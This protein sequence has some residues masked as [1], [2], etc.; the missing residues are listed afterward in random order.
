MALFSS[1]YT[2]YGPGDPQYDAHVV[3]PGA[4]AAAANAAGQPGTENLN[5]TDTSWLSQA[6]NPALV[7]AL[8]AA[9]KSS[10]FN[11]TQPPPLAAARPTEVPAGRPRQAASLD[12]LVQLLEKQR[13]QYGTLSGQPVQRSQVLGL[14]GF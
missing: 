8:Q 5:Q 12:Q 14:L 10:V 1:G 11:P 4:L 9:S 6:T 13:A 2:S 3:D 7:Q